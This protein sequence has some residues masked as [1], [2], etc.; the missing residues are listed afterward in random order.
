MKFKKLIVLVTIAFGCVL[1]P[2]PNFAAEFNF[3]VTPQASANQIDKTKTYFD[4]LLAPNQTDELSVN[5][6]NDTAQKVVVEA[7]INSA[8]TIV[9]VW[10]NIAPIRLKLI[11]RSNII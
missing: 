8:T 10:W 9:M 4:L 11:K 1:F 3:A 7:Q 2:Q 6:R 5:L